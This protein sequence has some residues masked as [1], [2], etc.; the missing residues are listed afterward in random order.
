MKKLIQETPVQ[1]TAELLVIV[2]VLATLF[3]R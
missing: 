1:T 3:I 2:L